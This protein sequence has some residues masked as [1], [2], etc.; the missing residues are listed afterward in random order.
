[1]VPITGGPIVRLEE[2]G[3][4]HRAVWK[5]DGTAIY[6]YSGDFQNNTWTHVFRRYDLETGRSEHLAD[7]LLEKME[8][9]PADGALYFISRQGFTRLDPETGFV[10]VVSEER[11]DSFDLSPDGR[12]AVVL[13]GNDVTILDLEFPSSNPLQ[14][15]QVTEDELA[16]G[17]IP[18]ARERLVTQ[19]MSRANMSTSSTEIASRVSKAIGVKQILWIDNERLWCVVHHENTSIDPIIASSPEVRVGIAQLY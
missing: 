15:E 1:M 11:F 17:Q 6:Y 16:L 4:S 14:A 9:S 5:E 3:H 10:E 8:V 18:A 19:R 13:K 12:Q 2:V 7:E